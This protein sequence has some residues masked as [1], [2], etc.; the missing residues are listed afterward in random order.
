MQLKVRGISNWMQMAC[1]PSRWTLTDRH[2]G[3]QHQ[4]GQEPG[5]R[6]LKAEV[7][8]KASPQVVLDTLTDLKLRRF[9]SLISLTKVLK[10]ISYS[11]DLLYMRAE[12]LGQVRM[13]R[14]LPTF[15][16]H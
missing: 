10:D 11:L 3:R 4:Q 15:S 1:V 7:H 8:V 5:R 9:F 12:S 14:A 2:A 6:S 13:S 16:R